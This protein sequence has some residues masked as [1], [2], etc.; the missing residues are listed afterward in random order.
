MCR[1]RRF[2]KNDVFWHNVLEKKKCYSKLLEVPLA[3]SD[4]SDLYKH[5]RATLLQCNKHAAFLNFSLFATIDV[6]SYCSLLSSPLLPVIFFLLVLQLE[7][8][9]PLPAFEY[10]LPVCFYRSM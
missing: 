7:E 10:P 5:A 8:H 4:L 3:N 1:V 6:E 2:I 9:C